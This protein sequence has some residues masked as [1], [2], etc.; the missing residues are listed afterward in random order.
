MSILKL[1]FLTT[2]VSVSVYGQDSIK[3]IDYQPIDNIIDSLSSFA[4]SYPPT[5]ED[6]SQLEKA[7]DLFRSLIKR[8]DLLSKDK[9]DNY[10]TESR[11]GEIY[12]MG[13]NLDMKDAWKYSEKHLKK[14]IK[15]RAGVPRPYFSLGLLYVNSDITLAPKAEELFIKA[16]DLSPDRQFPFAYQA[17]AFAYYYQG[18]FK[19]AIGALDTF[20]LYYPDDEQGVNM[21]NIII[22][23]MKK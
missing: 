12:R 7:N 11:F 19:K 9:P 15:L 17:L 5:I 14:A 23:K 20:L 18:K 3:T 10:E 2:I 6:S 4:D 13:H 1:L 22:Q 16:I 8:M 21:K